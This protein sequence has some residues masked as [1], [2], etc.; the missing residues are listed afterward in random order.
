MS[1]KL[2]DSPWFWL[3]MFGAAAVAALAAVA[4][5]H[6]RRQERLVRMQAARERLQ[7]AAVRSAA[8]PNS[9][10]P[11]TEDSAP[12]VVEQ[13]HVSVRPLMVFL[14]SALFVAALVAGWMQ[15]RASHAPPGRPPNEV[16]G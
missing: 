8:G 6:V 15:V 9:S 16:H 13:P 5:K 4:P 14:A 10:P 1:G 3:L 7:S 12:W 2:S 11:S